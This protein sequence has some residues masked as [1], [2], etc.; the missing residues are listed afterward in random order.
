MVPG[1][2]AKATKISGPQLPDSQRIT[3]DLR[4]VIVER[5]KAKR[6]AFNFSSGIA[7][8]AIVDVINAKACTIV[9]DHSMD[10]PGGL[11]GM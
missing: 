9:F 1:L 11:D 6:R 4:Q 5:P 3:V 2:N 7:I 10:D 8:G